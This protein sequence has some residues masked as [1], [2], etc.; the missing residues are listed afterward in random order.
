[1]DP[2]LADFLSY[3][4]LAPSQ[5]YPNVFRIVMGTVKL[6]R[7]LRLELSMYDI[8][9]TYIF[10]NNTKIEAFSLRPR[11]VNYTLVNG[12]PDTNLG[13]DED[14]L[15]VSGEWHLPG[16]WCPT[17]EGVPGLTV[18]TRPIA[19]SL[20]DAVLTFLSFFCRLL[21]KTTAQDFD[22]DQQPSSG[23]ESE[24]CT[25]DFGQPRSASLLLHYM[26][27]THSNLSC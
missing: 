8:V 11:D 7:R 14:F 12:L 25:E 24:L 5:V 21:K 2:L 20:H 18:L 16:R 9:L 1:M 10:H 6:N 19:W 17:K 26:S 15:I 13:F 3:F 4:S 23:W 22:K 27:H